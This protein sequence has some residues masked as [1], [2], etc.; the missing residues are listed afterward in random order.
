M[1]SDNSVRY[2]RIENVV[3]LL[4]MHGPVKR[5]ALLHSNQEIL[6]LDE[7]GEALA[8]PGIY[9]MENI[10]NGFKYHYIKAPHL[11]STNGPQFADTLKTGS[12]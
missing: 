1:H 12:F 9:Q 2:Q 5:L 4:P 8:N 3:A 11:R 7:D 10:C 6:T